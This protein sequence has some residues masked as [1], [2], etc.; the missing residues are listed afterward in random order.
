MSSNLQLIPIRQLELFRN[1]VRIEN[2]DTMSEAEKK[3]EIDLIDAQLAELEEL[4]AV[5]AVAEN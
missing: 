5:V 3:A 4:A 1:K 2:D